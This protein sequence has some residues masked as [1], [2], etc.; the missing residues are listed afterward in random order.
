[1]IITTSQTV[2]NRSIQEYLGLVSGESILGSKFMETVLNGVNSPQ[3]CTGAC[4]T[5]LNDSR[6][7]AIDEMKMKA[8]LIGADALIAVD[9]DYVEM[10]DQLLLISVS[11]TA[12]KLVEYRD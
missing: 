2:Q 1:M 12:V 4:K 10:K 9:I 11:G 7:A 6:Q 8:E 3:G 5:T